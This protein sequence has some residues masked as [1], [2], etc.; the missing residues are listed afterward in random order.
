MQPTISTFDQ[1]HN[2]VITEILQA[3]CKHAFKHIE[4]MEESPHGVHPTSFAAA[5]YVHLIKAKALQSN[6]T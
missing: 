5:I 2:L 1:H 4:E 3:I 6:F